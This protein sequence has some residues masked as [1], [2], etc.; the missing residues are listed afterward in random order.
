MVQVH[1]GVAA[2]AQRNLLKIAHRQFDIAAERLQLSPDLRKLLRSH[3]RQLTV[4]FPV[5][6]DD[7]RI[8]M[9]TG[10]RIQ[11][12]TA[13]GPAKGGTRFSPTLTADEVKAL[14]MWMT[15]KCAV[16]G[17]P[18]GGAKGGVVCDPS[19]LSSGELERLTR[20]YA[21]EISVVLGP[22]C[23]IP[24]PDLGTNAQTMAWMMDTYS[25]NR[26]HSVP[27]IVT[28]K[29][30]AIGGSEGRLEGTGHGCAIT[31]REAARRLGLQLAGAEVVVQG[32]GNVGS[33][34]AE[35]LAGMGCKIIAISDVTGGVVAREGIDLA[36]AGAWSR[37]HGTLAGFGPAISNAE[38]LELPCDILVP[39]ALENQINGRNA[40]RV[41]AQIVA[42]AANGPV[43]PEADAILYDR[44][45]LQ[46]PDILANSG[47]VVVS[48]LEWVQDLQSFFWNEADVNRRLEE[49]VVRSF[50]EVF[51]LADADQVHP[52]TAAQMLAIRRVVEAVTLRGIF[53]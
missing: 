42:E 47:G 23:D 30:L 18:F 24:G 29:P 13:R 37:E 9:F 49:I 16:V 4:E 6:M 11:H 36:A 14:A 1:A 52:R 5:R 53:P 40:P 51:R 12:N 44:G 21:S 41:R 50:D 22:D 20:R 17:I 8:E 43:T 48:Y 26:G 10:F 39:A 15:W 19:A 28:G 27:A 2:P 46:I 32:F 35:T 25:M 31:V 34:T 7:G 38:L 45:I 3:Q 33:V